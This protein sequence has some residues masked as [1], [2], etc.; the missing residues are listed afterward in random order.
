MNFYVRPIFSKESC[1][2][3]DYKKLGS[4]NLFF[5]T[6]EIISRN[7]KKINKKFIRLKDIKLLEK[8]ELKEVSRQVKE[9]TFPRKKIASI[10]FD[11][12]K[13]MGI[14][15]VTPDSFSDGGKF[16]TL[17]ESTKYAAQ[18]IKDGADIIDI[19]GES[20]RPGATTVSAKKEISRVIPTIKKIKNKNKKIIISLDTRKPEVMKMGIA[21]GIDIINDVSGLRYSNKSIDII[22]Q[23]NTPFVLMHSIKNPKTMQVN[24]NYDDV[25]LDV[26]DFFKKKIALCESKKIDKKSIIL[27]PGIGFGKTVKQNLNLITN[28]ALLHSLG[29]PVLL[30]SSRKSFIGKLHKN[31]L[32]E[33]RIG[34]SIATIIH[35]L[36]QGVQI[37]RV[38]DV[39]ETS[40]AIK[41]YK[42]L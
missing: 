18:M 34:G 25:L 7:K 3:K 37:F 36:N 32:E 8:K 21:N 26:Y 33:K 35:A 5:N 28:I 30:G 17:Y 4:S 12:P 11:N 27:D 42:K 15:N 1:E 40:Q 38:H 14:L 22:K 10:K 19:G 39:F 29:C 20:T 24:I 31:A 23:K 16:N 13:I 6:I 9:I 41:I 2:S